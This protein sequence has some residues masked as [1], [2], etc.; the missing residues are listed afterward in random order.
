MQTLNTVNAPLA[1]Q[2]IVEF[3]DAALEFPQQIRWTSDEYYRLAE[4]GFF[5]GKR[6]ELIEGEIFTMAPMGSSH[7]TGI[8]ILGELLRESFGKG[9]F[10]RIQ[11]PLDVDDSSQPE[12]DVAVLA[13]S[14]REYA[15][16]YPKTVVLAAEV[17][18][19]SL[20]LDRN[21]KARLYARSSVQEYW[22]VNLQAPCLEVYRKPVDDPNLGFIYSERT[23]IGE[24]QS[25]S[26]L[27]KPKLKIK[28]ADILP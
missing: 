4:L 22:I 28:V 23:V 16:A 15:K 13:G 17:S 25:I 2:L 14:P 12:P 20:G 1:Q 3:N 5:E 26:P 19:S 21:V 18:N 27:A 11:L 9:Y 7:A 8:A 10:V 24:H 6:V